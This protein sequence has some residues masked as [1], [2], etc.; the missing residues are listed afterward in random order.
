MRV[1][2]N[3]KAGGRGLNHN[4]TLARAAAKTAGRK[5]KTDAQAG[6][7]NRHPNGT[8]AIPCS[9]P[10]R[11]RAVTKLSFLSGPGGRFRRVG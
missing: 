11:P 4:E 6:D 3:V 8:W 5:V 10:A 2:T 1:K 9:I 7:L